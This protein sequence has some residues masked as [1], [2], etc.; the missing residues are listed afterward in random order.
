MADTDGGQF[1]DGIRYGPQQSGAWHGEHETYGTEQ[2]FME[3]EKLQDLAGLPYQGEWRS[4]YANPV[5]EFI[6]ENPLTNLAVDARGLLRRGGGPSA[7]DWAMLGLSAAPPVKIAGTAAFNA[8]KAVNQTP[9]DPTRRTVLQRAGAMV[10]Q[11]KNTLSTI[12]DDNPFANLPLAETFRTLKSPITSLHRL[13]NMKQ[14]LELTKDLD[15]IGALMK[16]TDVPPISQATHDKIMKAA[17]DQAKKNRLKQANETPSEKVV[18]LESMRRHKEA[19][20]AVEKKAKDENALRDKV[21]SMSEDQFENWLSKANQKDVEVILETQGVDV[22][23]LLTKVTKI[24]QSHD[25]KVV[26][27]KMSYK[28]SRITHEIWAQE[29]KDLS[30][31][32]TKDL[33]RRLTLRLID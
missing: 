26:A 2:Q 6:A 32:E 19:V 9:F 3:G 29:T 10:A 30:L 27:E 18:R 24:M 17:G 15:Q 8:L 4:T 1:I 23:K 11:P 22:D 14:D 7:L 21:L 25:P 5:T 13:R 16:Q 12:L 28:P 31:S 33:A 20:A